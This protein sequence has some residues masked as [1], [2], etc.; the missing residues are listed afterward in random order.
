[1]GRQALTS[2]RY[3]LIMSGFYKTK[4]YGSLAEDNI[5][6]MGVCERMKK[7]RCV[8]DGSGV[9]QMEKIRRAYVAKSSPKVR[10][11]VANLEAVRLR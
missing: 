7:R 6:I 1:M 11:E 3:P 2:E 5:S 9:P 4:Y 8:L 10:C